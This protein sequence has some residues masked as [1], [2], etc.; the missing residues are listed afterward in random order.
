[1]S[2]FDD[3]TGGDMPPAADTPSASSGIRPDAERKKLLA[4]ALQTQVVQG[5]R[6]ESHS[7]FSAVV[8]FGKDVNHVL[9]VLIAIFTCGLWL[10]PWLVMGVVGGE[11]RVL[12]SVDD[13]GNVL[14][15]DL[16]K[17]K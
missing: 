5:G 9:H 11:K 8:V 13:Y 17:R 15:Q 3:S 2:E 16:G 12:V 4:D 7:E 10:I 6:I 1:M 14:N